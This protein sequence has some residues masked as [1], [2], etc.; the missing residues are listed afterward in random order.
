MFGQ[1]GLL[2][3]GL[4]VLQSGAQPIDKTITDFDP[5]PW[6]EGAG[7]VSNGD[8]TATYTGGSGTTDLTAFGA[9][10]QD[11]TYEVSFTVTG[12]NEGNINLRFGDISTPDVVA[13]ADGTYTQTL[14]ATG[15]TGI[16]FR[17]A[18]V[19]TGSVVLSDLSVVKV[20]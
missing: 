17:A 18:N 11:A 1:F 4:G 20:G 12:L 15:G 9:L 16:R 10:E 14:V 13:S 19:L 5:A 6:T 7:W 2:G 8:G 3:L